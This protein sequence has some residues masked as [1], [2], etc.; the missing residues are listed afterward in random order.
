M[1]LIL[2]AS[3][4]LALLHREPGA[5]RVEQ[6]LQDALVSAVNW[7]EVIQKSL[8]R[9][10]D[11]S[12][13]RTGFIEVGVAFEPFTAEQGE[14][15]ARIWER[16]RGRGLSLADRACLALAMERKLPILT[17][18]RAWSELDLELD[19]QIIR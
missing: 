17:A 7:A 18:D 1:S 8:W 6:S 4:L 16:T 12:G 9:H 2:D 3:A 15:A 11:I 19:I 5:E 10:A 13:L 14:I